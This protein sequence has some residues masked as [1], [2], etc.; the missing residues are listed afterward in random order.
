MTEPLCVVNLVRLITAWP[1][2]NRLY[3]RR[4]YC[5]NVVVSGFSM[6]LVVFYKFK[7]VY[8]I[9]FNTLQY[10]NAPGLHSF[11]RVGNKF[12][13]QKL[14]IL[15]CLERVC[16]NC[17]DSVVAQWVVVRLAMDDEQQTSSSRMRT[18]VV[19]VDLFG[20]FRN[21]SFVVV[22]FV[23]DFLREKHLVKQESASI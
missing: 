13:A 18:F 20:L 10:C 3:I 4:V 15:Y 5:K 6:C 11:L 9:A 16:F 21:K 2:I 23:F 17:F 14:P 8:N 1:L 19:P 12:S 7:I 22:L